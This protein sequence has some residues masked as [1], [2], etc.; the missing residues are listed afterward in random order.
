VVISKVSSLLIVFLLFMY[1]GLWVV[2]YS[3]GFP[4]FQR[5]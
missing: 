2:P 1:K 5:H 4:S 3:G